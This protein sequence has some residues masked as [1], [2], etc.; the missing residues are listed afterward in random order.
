MKSVALT[1]TRKAVA[2]CS[3]DGKSTR[4][5][6]RVRRRVQKVALLAD[7][8]PA[9]DR[10]GVAED[11]VDAPHLLRRDGVVLGQEGSQGVVRQNFFERK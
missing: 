2:L 5:R 1:E 6:F 9:L 8:A 11:P 10:D 3:L 7:D 4:S